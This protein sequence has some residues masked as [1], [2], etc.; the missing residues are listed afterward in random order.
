MS[1]YRG[2]L[3]LD[4]CATG[5]PALMVLVYIV[6]ISDW[7]AFFNSCWLHDGIVFMLLV[8]Q[9]DSQLRNQMVT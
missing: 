9:W 1:Q 8:K 4:C 2:V 3:S 7:L 5:F 6:A